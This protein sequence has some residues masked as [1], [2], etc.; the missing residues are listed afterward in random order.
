MVELDAVAGPEFFPKL[1]FD[2][3][4]LGRK[5]GPY[6]IADQIQS[7]TAA[8]TAVSK[9]IQALQGLDGFLK[10]SV[11]PL[12]IGLAGA[13]LGKRSDDFHTMQGEELC[14]VRLGGQEQH[15]QVASIHHV[16]TQCPALFDQPAKIWIELRC[17]PP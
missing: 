5:K 11:T 10:D 3:L 2:R 7:E 12:R 9:C 4:L 17:P 16:A 6:R 1:R 14:Q 8:G 13:V 15:G